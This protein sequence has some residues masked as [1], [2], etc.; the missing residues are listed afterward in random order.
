MRTRHIVVAAVTIAAASLVAGAGAPL[1]ARAEDP[2]PGTITVMGTGTVPSV[3]DTATISFGVVTQAT[4][5]AQA[6]SANTTAAERMIAAIKGAGIDSKDVHTDFVT[7][8]PRYSER[9]DEIV[10]YTASNSVSATIRDLGRAGAVIDA[11]VGAGANSVNGP[12]LEPSDV[13]ALYQDALKRAVADART[14]GEA[15]AAAGG[16]TLGAVSSMSEGSQAPIPFAAAAAK[17]AAGAV[18]IE[19]GTQDVTASVT[20]VFRAS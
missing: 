1:V 2:Q 11:A 19:P 4:T 5:A 9:G 18:P 12:F 6:M 8:S 20:V 7:L 10:G 14:K 16:M 3:P 17:D 15:L 13:T